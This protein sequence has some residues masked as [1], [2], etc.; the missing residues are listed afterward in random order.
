MENAETQEDQAQETQIAG[1]AETD[2]KQTSPTPNQ[3]KETPGTLVAEPETQAEGATTEQQVFCDTCGAANPLTARYCQHCSA[4]LPFRHTTGM[5]VGPILLANRYQLLS[6]I[7]QGG[8]GAVYKAA[9]TRFNNRPVAIKEMSTSGLPAARLQEAVEAFEREAHLLA[10]LLHPNLPRIYEHFAENDRSY[11]VMDFIEGQTLEEYLAKVGGK[12]LPIDQVMKW[13]EQLCDVLN[14]LHSHQPPIVF[15]DLKPA[16]VMISDNGHIYLIDFGI[17]RIFKPG[18]QHDTVALG[19]PGYAAPEQY[20]KA[21]ST[22]RSD[23]YSLGALL[24]CLLT[25]VDPSE[26]PFFFRPASQL[27]PAVNP[28]LEFLL[29]QMLDM[30]SERRPA[31]A[32]AVWEALEQAVAGKTTSMSLTMTGLATTGMYSTSDPLL[33]QAYRAY[34]QR[35][36]DEAIK[37]YSR[38]LQK[39]N[40]NPLAWQGYGLTQ[41]SRLQH[42]DALT[43]FERALQLDPTLIA[44]WNGK[45]TALSRLRRHQEA[46]VSFE[47]AIELDPNNAASWN[48]KGAT[49]NALGRPAPALDAFEMALRLDPRLVQAWNNKGLVLNEMGRYQQAQKAFEESLDL[50]KNNTHA[51]FG[52]GQALYAQRRLKQGLQYFDMALAI[53]DTFAEAWSRRGNVL[54][55]LGNANAALNSYERALRLNPRLA[56]AWNGKGGVL[57]QVGQ[58]FEAL[59]AYNYA[60][61]IDP[62][63]A[64]AWNGKGNAH[65]ALGSFSEALAAYQRALQLNPRLTTAWHNQSL[66]LNRLGRY[67]ESLRSANEAIRLSQ[68]DP[69]HWLRKAEAL[70]A[71]RRVKEAR[72]AEEQAALLRRNA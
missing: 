13:A 72:A 35:N 62:N 33:A 39:D 61:D 16:N 9:D 21:Q 45:G 60:L 53:D 68:K 64:L 57:R 31:S 6:C 43:S 36:L 30:D 46:L 7:G 42:Q 65:Y 4:L 1:E 22:P 55:E 51:L 11:L 15:R 5:L 23:I 10:D 12:P 48:G 56:A 3:E 59:K 58:P 29:K 34:T 41:G 17:A 32:K 40:K 67:E 2:Q 24:H 19:S 44:S 69:D 8:M 38:A 49:L 18:K 70:R 47:R 20:G 54:D 37:L 26:Q 27:N 71:L 52:K 50:D 63:Y 14:Y 28:S 66:V 25:G